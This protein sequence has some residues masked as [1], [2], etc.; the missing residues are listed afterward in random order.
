MI[1]SI[2]IQNF[3]CFETLSIQRC[4]RINVIVGDNGSGKTT[5]VEALF[6]ALGTTTELGVRYRQQR[7]HEGGFSGPSKR[8]EEAI[9]R[10]FFYK[11]DWTQTISIELSGEGPEARSVKIMRGPPSRVSIPISEDAD[12]SEGES[13]TASIRFIWQDSTGKERTVFVPKLTHGRYD[14][15]GTEED[16]DDF[17]YFAATQTAG[18]VENAGRFSELSRAQRVGKFVRTFTTEYDWIEDLSIEV[19]AGASAVYATLKGQKDKVP[20]PD[21]SG[22]INRMIRVITH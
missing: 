3:R 10:D 11:R 19:A 17:F 8:I 13:M 6:L 2:D 1:H 20:L 9:W 21:V 4:Q 15:E 18:S 12:Q 16:L 5:L 22:G 7:G 14:F